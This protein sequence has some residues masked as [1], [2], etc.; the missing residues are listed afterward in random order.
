MSRLVLGTA[1]TNGCLLKIDNRVLPHKLYILGM[2]FGSHSRQQ[3][4]E[5][6]LWRGLESSV[7]ISDPVRN[8]VL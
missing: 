5:S 2:F 3:L 1:R 7:T 6:G 8:H 4:V